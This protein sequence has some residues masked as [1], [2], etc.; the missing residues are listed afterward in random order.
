MDIELEVTHPWASSLP[1]NDGFAV[2]LRALTDDRRI[3]VVLAGIDL[4]KASMRAD[5]LTARFWSALLLNLKQRIALELMADFDDRP[6]V[7]EVTSMEMLRA[8]DRARSTEML[9]DL[10]MIGAHF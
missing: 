1:P 4:A 10:T 9:P 3:M 6:L 7:V 2:G 5:E 8:M